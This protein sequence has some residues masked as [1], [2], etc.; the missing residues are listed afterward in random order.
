MGRLG[1]SDLKQS[2]GVILSVKP[3]IFL[4]H[5]KPWTEANRQR[6]GADA[7]R[8]TGLDVTERTF[9]PISF[10]DALRDAASLYRQLRP[11]RDNVIVLPLFRLSATTLPVFQVLFALRLPFYFLINASQPNSGQGAVKLSIRQRKWLALFNGLI[12]RL[13]HWLLGVKAANGIVIDGTKVE[14]IARKLCPPSSGKTKIIFSHSLDYEQF[15][16]GEGNSRSKTNLFSKYAVFIDQALDC[17][18]DFLING[19]LPPVSANYA[20]EMQEFFEEIEKQF[21]VKIIVAIHPKRSANLP[22]TGM[23][24]E[25]GAIDSLISNSEFV[26]GHFSTALNMAAAYSKPVII[27][28]TDE[29]MDTAWTNVAIN[30]YADAFGVAVLTRKDIKTRIGDFKSTIESNANFKEHFL[31]HPKSLGCSWWQAILD[32]YTTRAVKT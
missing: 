9:C 18:P 10:W 29:L 15:L 21:G 20:Q 8:A 3:G 32:D 14:R 31:C 27:V 16:F 13:P 5:N 12:V 22:F 1:V 2:I 25:R 19:H 7:I 28:G 4:I 30:A 24:A 6:F 11:I 26:I 17:H 23:A